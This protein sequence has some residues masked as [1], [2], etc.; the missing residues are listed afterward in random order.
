MF[1]SIVAIVRRDDEP[2]FRI[3]DSRF[4]CG[5]TEARIDDGMNQAETR[6]GQ[7]GHDLFG[8]FRKI[9]RDA[10]TFFHS[11]G[12]EGIC[13]AIDLAVQLGI[14]K[15]PFFVL[16][17][18]PNDRNLVSS[19]RVHVT[20]QTIIRNIAFPSQKPFCPWVVPLQYRVPRREPFQLLGNAVPKFFRIGD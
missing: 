12:F 6:T 1:A 10:I 9:N 11:K 3:V 8:N 14:G 16:L 2:G 7:H 18:H 17:S 15:D 4:Q 5:R 20:I 13:A 19:P